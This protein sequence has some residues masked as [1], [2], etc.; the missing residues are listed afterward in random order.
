MKIQSVTVFCGSKSGN[1]P[2][3]TQQ[4]IELGT[5]LGKNGIQLVYG[6]G[7]KGIM[8]AIADA[9]L[10]N[11]GKVLGIMPKLLLEWEAQHE[12]LTE[13]IVTETMHDRKKILYDKADVAIILPGGMGTMDEL[14][15][16]LTWNNLNIH[17]K[18]V[19]ILN[20]EGF[21]TPL[22]ALMDHMHAEGFMYE[23]WKTRIIVAKD[24]QE[25]METIN[26][27]SE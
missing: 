15:E 18:K 17:Q 23:D 4:A 7:G 14:F 27:W 25:V 2:G 24:A 21:Y 13:L 6:G 9:V 5:A 19:I 11:H 10:D 3:F 22:I 8:G 1:K 12:G 20:W 16:M 26:A